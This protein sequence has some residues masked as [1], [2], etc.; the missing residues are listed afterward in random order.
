MIRLS[1]LQYSPFYFW[2]KD[3]KKYKPHESGFGTV[4]TDLNGSQCHVK[5]SVE[6]IKDKLNNSCDGYVNL[7][8]LDREPITTSF[9]KTVSPRTIQI[10]L[11]N[12]VPSSVKPIVIFPIAGYK[13]LSLKVTQYNKDYDG[14][15]I[16]TTLDPN[17]ANV[18]NL[19][20]G[21]E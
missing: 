1:L 2:N 11:P 20:M 15:T 21:V 5:E 16:E 13:E 9:N 14:T 8:E 7:S 4:V 10:E 17:K 12:N 6:E 19:N 18:I 3:I